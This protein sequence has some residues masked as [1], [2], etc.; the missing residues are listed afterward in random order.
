MAAHGL[1]YIHGTTEDFAFTQR[2]RSS[3]EQSPRSY[4]DP[5]VIKPWVRDPL[6]HWPEKEDIALSEEL[7][8]VWRFTRSPEAKR[9]AEYT[10]RGNYVSD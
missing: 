2:A 3:Y 8:P 1:R 7:N 4:K 6:R 5:A 10:I 9:A